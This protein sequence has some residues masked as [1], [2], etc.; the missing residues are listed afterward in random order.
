MYMV[1]TLSFGK[2]KPIKAIKNLHLENQVKLPR[3]SS[4]LC[5]SPFL[6]QV[7]C[8]FLISLLTWSI[9]IGRALGLILRNKLCKYLSVLLTYF[10]LAFLVLKLPATLIIQT[11]LLLRASA[12]NLGQSWG[13]RVRS[14]FDPE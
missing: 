12:I 7:L 1:L 2:S 14:N 10:L 6:F 11:F 3:S 4:S 8:L 9:S 13:S 5:S